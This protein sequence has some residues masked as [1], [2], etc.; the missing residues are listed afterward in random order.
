[1]QLKKTIVIIFGVLIL[2]VGAKADIVPPDPSSRGSTDYDLMVNSIIEEPGELLDVF[3]GVRIDE[4]NPLNAYWVVNVSA[5]STGTVYKAFLDIDPSHDPSLL[6]ASIV[7]VV[8][9]VSVSVK[10]G[11]IQFGPNSYEV[12]VTKIGNP[13][14][15][16][17][18]N[19]GISLLLGN[20]T[21]WDLDSFQG[22][23]GS[24][25]MGPFSGSASTV[26][27]PVLGGAPTAAAMSAVPELPAG[28]LI[29]LIFILG[30]VVFLS[31]FP[32]QKSKKESF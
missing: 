2:A 20:G 18:A 23:N 11:S 13:T 1:M 15:G 29:P 26:S 25:D 7:D 31:R 32:F 9:N 30:G 8:G 4:E 22:V 19:E 28:L 17:M 12:A 24:S 3:S 5:L 6:A 27:L 14:N 10:V 21:F 16:L